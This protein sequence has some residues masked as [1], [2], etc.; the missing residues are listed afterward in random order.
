[1]ILYKSCPRCSG[2][3]YVEQDGFGSYVSCLAGGHIAYPGTA[4]MVRRDMA[5][6]L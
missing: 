4:L 2:D 3:R 6:A 1:M 5:Q